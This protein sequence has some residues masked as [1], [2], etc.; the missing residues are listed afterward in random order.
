[1]ILE[2]PNINNIYIHPTIQIHKLSQMII[3]FFAFFH[4]YNYHPYS[5]SA[6]FI[7]IYFKRNIKLRILFHKPKMVP[8]YPNPFSFQST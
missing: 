3:N 7:I 5:S 8:S 1:M 4:C 2:L 6:S